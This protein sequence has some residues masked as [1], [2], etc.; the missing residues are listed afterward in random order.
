[1]NVSH[2]FQH[3]LGKSKSVS[4]KPLV[5]ENLDGILIMLVI[6]LLVIGLIMVSSA[7]I[8]IADS[9]TSSP[10]YYLYR[11]LI[12]VALGLVAAAVI[13]K[14]RLVY[15]EKSGMIL[16]AQLVGYRLVF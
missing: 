3:K 14:I 12:A 9:K 2:L 10:F 13:F 6:S 7:S 16:M 15:W 11:Q 1:M 4:E 8:S 5:F